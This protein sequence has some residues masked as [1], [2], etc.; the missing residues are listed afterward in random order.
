MWVKNGLKS[1]QAYAFS[2]DRRCL[3]VTPAHVVEPAA[4]SIRLTNLKGNAY[5][6]S[7]LA[8]DT[9]RDIALLQLATVGAADGHCQFAG[10]AIHIG[11]LEELESSIS[12]QP[13]AW[14]D[15]IASPAGGLDRF[16]VALPATLP[17][18][19]AKE[20]MVTAKSHPDFQAPRAKAGGVVSSWNRRRENPKGRFGRLPIQG[21]SGAMLWVGDRQ[22]GHFTDGRYDGDKLAWERPQG[23]L[24]GMLLRVSGDRAHLLSITAI[25]DFIGQTLRPIEVSK[26]TLLAPGAQVSDGRRGQFV[27]LTFQFGAGVLT[28]LSYE[29]DLGDEDLEFKGLEVVYDSSA[30]P[31]HRHDPLSGFREDP[32]RSLDVMVNVSQFRPAAGRDWRS[33]NCQSY[34]WEQSGRDGGDDHIKLNCALAQAVVARGVRVT[35]RGLPG[36]WRGLRLNLSQ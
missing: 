14:F 4:A 2:V 15:L 22:S 24:A 31:D 29:F 10:D 35:L 16:D 25:S 1:G 32:H 18:V 30:D 11:R 7:I 19:T 8:S 23:Y 17:F 20:F 5:F 26:L 21:N 12:G 3:A 28:D 33:I 6:A 36:R 13:G 9:V 34:K 27:G